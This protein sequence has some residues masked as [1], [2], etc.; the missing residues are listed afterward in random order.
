M[1]LVQT[2]LIF[3][4]IRAIRLLIR[5]QNNKLASTIVLAI[6][7]LY[8]TDYDPPH[9]SPISLSQSSL[10]SFLVL[11][12]EAK[13]GQRSLVRWSTIVGFSVVGRRL[14]G[15]RSLVDNQQVVGCWSTIVGSWLWVVSHQS[16]V[17]FDQL[18]TENQAANEPSATA[19]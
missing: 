18:Q 17:M 10:L 5:R 4:T 9:R 1:E 7:F 11:F 12:L 19:A 3:F 13:A 8:L 6:Y 14:P 2:A 16:P 15:C